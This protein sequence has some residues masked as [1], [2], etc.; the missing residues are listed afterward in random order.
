MWMKL[1]YGG[2]SNHLPSP[3]GSLE[4][5]TGSIDSYPVTSDDLATFSEEI[6]MKTG[7]LVYTMYN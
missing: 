7:V 4:R 1:N 2:H 6:K 3:A 5:V